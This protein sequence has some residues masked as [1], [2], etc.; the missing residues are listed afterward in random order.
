MQACRCHGEDLPATLRVEAAATGE[1]TRVGRWEPGV[2]SGDDERVVQ[3]VTSRL[4]ID[5]S[6]CR[7]G[8]PTVGSC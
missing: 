4:G 3:A 8:R 1:Q 7:V 5:P 2:L 6:R